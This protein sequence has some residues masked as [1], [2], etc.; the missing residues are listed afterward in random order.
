MARKFYYPAILVV[1]A[2]LSVVSL[3][4]P[5][6]SPLAIDI[7]PS[8]LALY[9]NSARTIYYAAFERQSAPFA[10]WEPCTHPEICGDQGIKP[11]LSLDLPYELI[12]HWYP[13]AEVT[14]NWWSLVPDADAPD[15]Y[16]MD[17]PHETTVP[18]PKRLL[19]GG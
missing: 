4:L 1:V 11:G 5:P 9:N 6:I 18:T 19:P 10:R 2:V 12:Y 16:R 15:G 13:A 17:G 8:K 7:R 3:G 14:V